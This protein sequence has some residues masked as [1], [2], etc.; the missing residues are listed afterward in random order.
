MLGY[1]KVTYNGL[2]LYEGKEL[3]VQMLVLFQKFNSVPKLKV[4]TKAFLS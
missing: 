1:F 2:G 4:S 3:E